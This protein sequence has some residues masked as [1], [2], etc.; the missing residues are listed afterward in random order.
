MCLGF[1]KW[2]FSPFKEKGGETIKH[3]PFIHSFIH[4]FVEREKQSTMEPDDANFDDATLGVVSRYVTRFVFISLRV[5]FIAT[6][7]T[8]SEAF[9]EWFWCLIFP[10]F[11]SK[12]SNFENSAR[13]VCRV[14]SSLFSRPKDDL[15][16]SS[17]VLLFSTLSFPTRAESL[18]GTPKRPTERRQNTTNTNRRRSNPP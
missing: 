18:W 2:C 13:A 8:T 16:K 12:I 14:V 7:T 3:P 1:V 10:F 4:S 15:T 5:H 9:F 6:T 11:F 17:L